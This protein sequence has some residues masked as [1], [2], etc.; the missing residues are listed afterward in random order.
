MSCRTLELENKKRIDRPS[1]F[2]LHYLFLQ[3]CS[4]FPSSPSFRSRWPLLSLVVNQAMPSHLVMPSQPD[5]RCVSVLSFK[6]FLSSSLILIFCRKRLETG[7][8]KLLVRPRLRR[9]A[10]SLSLQ[11]HHAVTPLW[12]FRCRHESKRFPLCH[13]QGRRSFQLFRSRSL[14][15]YLEGNSRRRDRNARCFVPICQ[16]V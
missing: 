3:Q 2:L 16:L 12:S 7:M 6:A 11:H 10:S 15:R 4:L 9:S 8:W 13:R 5:G 1:I 14:C